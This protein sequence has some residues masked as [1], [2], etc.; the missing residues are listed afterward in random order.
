MDFGLRN[1]RKHTETSNYLLTEECK[2][3]ELGTEAIK[4]AVR[5]EESKN[6]AGVGVHKRAREGEIEGTRKQ[7]ETRKQRGPRATRP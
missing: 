1:I 5:F 7:V 2:Y 3:E 6:Q 4:R